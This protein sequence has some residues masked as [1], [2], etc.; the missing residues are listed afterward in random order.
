M[1]SPWWTSQSK[2][3]ILLALKFL[4][5]FFAAKTALFI[6]QNPPNWQ[7]SAPAWCPGGLTIANEFKLYFN[8]TLS[9]AIFAHSAAKK[10]ALLVSLI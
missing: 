1:E 4:I 6:K 10:A 9:A 8:Q 5:K 3:T 2:I 7:P